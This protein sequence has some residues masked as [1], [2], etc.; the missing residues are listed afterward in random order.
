LADEADKLTP[1]IAHECYVRDK[2]PTNNAC[3]GEMKEK[4][5][6]A[7]QLSCSHLIAGVPLDVVG[8]QGAFV[9]P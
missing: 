1:F 5:V 3:E 8:R 9:E 7:L 2:V 4:I 6:Y